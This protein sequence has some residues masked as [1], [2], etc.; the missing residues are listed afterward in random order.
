M[1]GKVTT[2]DLNPYAPPQVDCAGDNGRKRADDDGNA[3]EATDRTFGIDVRRQIV[4]GHEE[5]PEE[6]G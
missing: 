6:P 3:G 2:S 4:G 1:D 5:N